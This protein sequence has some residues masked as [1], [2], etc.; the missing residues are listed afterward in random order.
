MFTEQSLAHEEAKRTLSIGNTLRT[1]ARNQ[2]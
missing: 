1:I 2:H